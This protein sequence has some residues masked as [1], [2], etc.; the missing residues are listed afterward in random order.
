MKHLHYYPQTIKTFIIEQF[1]E[2]SPDKFNFERM[3][4]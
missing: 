2:L 4:E 3:D 1:P